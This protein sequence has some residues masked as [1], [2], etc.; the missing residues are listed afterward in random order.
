MA[1]FVSLLGIGCPG[2]RILVELGSLSVSFSTRFGIHPVLTQSFV[3]LK[4]DSRV[5]S[6]VCTEVRLG[7]HGSNVPLLLLPNLSLKKG[8]PLLSLKKIRIMKY[9]IFDL[10]QVLVCLPYFGVFVP[11]RKNDS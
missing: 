1:S 2:E 10:N 6:A 8:A 7:R 3:Y 4:T 5:C 11:K 9:K